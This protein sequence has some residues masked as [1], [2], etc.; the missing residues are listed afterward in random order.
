MVVFLIVL[1]ANNSAFA[2]DDSHGK[3]SANNKYGIHIL[4]ESDL[5]DAAKLVNGGGGEWGYVTIVIR[6]DERDSAYWNKMFKRFSE[7][8]LI[9]IVRIATISQGGI[10]EKP[11]EKDAG[12]WAEFLD[13][14]PW[15]V[16]N[17]YVV[18]FNEPNH[19]KEWG[20]EINPKE[21]SKIVRVYWEEL[22]KASFNFF[23]LS[24][25]FDAAALNTRETMDSAVFFEE[26]YKQDELVFTLFDGW[27][28]HS[29]PNPGFMG[30]PQ[31]D[32]KMSIRG[33]DWETNFLY[34]FGLRRNIPVFI[35]E[36]GWSNL[37]GES[38]ISENYRYAFERV[39]NDERIVAI[40][41]FVLNYTSYP[42]S[43]FSWINPS[44]GEY[45]SYYKV[46]MEIPKVKGKPEMEKREKKVKG[47]KTVAF[48]KYPFLVD[49]IRGESKIKKTFL[50]NLQINLIGTTFLL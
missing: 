24:A 22:K 38:K 36:T 7:L 50:Q 46:V 31:E 10:W 1:L 19:A 32:G 37:L 21:Y 5:D 13:S 41:P 18:L 42:F 6:K 47:R 49:Y 30:S 15:P 29:Y 28:S 16:K 14:L 11:N 20:G 44:T 8:K 26:M 17:R 39:W 23:V 4:N 45:Y 34:K 2:S 25:G 3:S 27:A 33:Y 12:A 35:T 40:T 9:P 48:E 43:M